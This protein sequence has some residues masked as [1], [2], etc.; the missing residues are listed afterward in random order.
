[1]PKFVSDLKPGQSPD[2]ST[3]GI[4]GRG[5]EPPDTRSAFW[6]S[7]TGLIVAGGMTL[8]NDVDTVP[9]LLFFIATLSL[10]LGGIISIFRDM[11]NLTIR[12][13]FKTVGIIAAAVFLFLAIMN[14][15]GLL[16]GLIK[17]PHI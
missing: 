1:M 11:A 8:G 5:T 7:T 9:K 16:S 14:S 13:Y 15:V 10:G 12:R 4:K 17:L 3:S 2:S 6:A